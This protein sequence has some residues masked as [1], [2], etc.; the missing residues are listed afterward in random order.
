VQDYLSGSTQLK[1]FYKYNIDTEGLTHAVKDR[2]NQRVDRPLLVKSLQQQYKHLGKHSR[3]L[4]NLDLLLHDNTFTVCTAHQPNLATGYLYF[5]YKILHAIKLAETLKQLFPHENFVPIYYMG[6]EDND[7]EELGSFRY[8]GKKFTWDGAGQKGAVGRMRTESLKPLFDELF[9]QFGPPGPNC[10]QLTDLLSKAYLEHGT[11]ADATHYLVNELF[12]RY[13]LIV[14]N[15]D[16][17]ELK[18]QFID[19]MKDDLLNHTAYE[20]VSQQ[21]SLLAEHHKVQAHP[22]PIN[23]F[24]LHEN[25]RERIEKVK[26]GWAVLNT[27]IRWNEEELLQELEQHP[28]RFSPNVI[29]RG[30]YQETILP[31]VTF[32]GGGA[33]LAYWLQLK[34]LFDHYG[35]FFPAV[36]LRQSVL[37]VHEKEAKLRARLGLSIADIFKPETDLVR[38]YI[39]Q[40]SKDD[41]QT[42]AEMK[43][44]E[45][46]LLQLKQK[47]VQ[48]DPTLRASAEAALAK[49][50]HQ[51]QVLEKKML[52]AEKR[53]MQD[54]LSQIVKLKT[55]LFPNTGLQERVENFMSYY[56]TYGSQYLDIIK[57]HIEPLAHQFLVVENSG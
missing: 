28:E 5:V 34:T 50:R 1:P 11:I 40:N 25:V 16:A 29:L 20:I 57:D 17:A 27:T 7:L 45:H 30:L 35:V 41:W 22:R 21:I 2:A 6:S 13:G 55:H 38:E 49:I 44:L 33:E 47:A 54:R 23:L 37:W 39:K 15:P 51:A 12:G 4:S 53:K 14:I 32:I 8:N 56:L 26:D 24:Y 46:I 18:R 10:E 3:V 19:V 48:L 31:D 42:D 43:N 9:R 52:R 36:H